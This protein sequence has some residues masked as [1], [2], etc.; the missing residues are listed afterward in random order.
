M[1]KKQRLNLTVLGGMALEKE[2]LGPDSMVNIGMPL[3]A[4]IYWEMA[5][6]L[7]TVV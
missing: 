2:L 5:I 3:V 6:V 4:A 7:T 1:A